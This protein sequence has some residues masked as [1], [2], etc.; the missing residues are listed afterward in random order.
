MMD[1]EQPTE[2]E[3]SRLLAEL[4]AGR[5]G[6]QCF[7][8]WEMNLMLELQQWCGGHRHRRL[9]LQRYGQAVKREFRDGRG[10]MLP[11]AEYLTRLEQKRARQRRAAPLLS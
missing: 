10:R 5:T 1:T 6:R 2:T 9:M 11:V 7:R 4:L 8:A 3:F